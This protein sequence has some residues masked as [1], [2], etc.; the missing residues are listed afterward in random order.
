MTLTRSAVASGRFAKLSSKLNMIADSAISESPLP[1]L[2]CKPGCAFCCHRLVEGVLPEAIAIAQHV[3]ET[4]NEEQIEALK[5]RI[6]QYEVGVL[7]YVK[8]DAPIFRERCPFLVDDLCSIY[9]HRPLD[10]RGYTSTD[11]SQCEDWMKG[12]REPPFQEAPLSIAASLKRGAI[13]ES[14]GAGLPS[15]TY[16]LMGAIGQILDLGEAAYRT[17][18]ATAPVDA[19]VTQSA[20]NTG[21]I[22]PTKTFSDLLQLPGFVELMDATLYGDMDTVSTLLA[23][24]DDPHFPALTDLVLPNVYESQDELEERWSK[25]GDAIGRF[26]NATLH[27]SA[28]FELLP[29]LN[30]FFWP[31]AGKDVR[32]YLER[33]KAKIFRDVIQPG[34]ASLAQPLPSR[35]RPG[36]FRLGFTSPR[37]TYFNG[38]RWATGWLA[39]LSPEIETF[40][41]NLYDQEDTFTGLW[42]RLSDHYF[43]LPVPSAKAAEL[44]RSFDLDALIFTDIGMG[45]RDLQMSNLR[46]ARRQFTAWGHPVTSGSPT[47]DGYLSSELMEPI[48]AQRHYSE[49]LY[50]LPG[51]GLTYPRV[52]VAP[53]DIDPTRFGLPA[54]GFYF[55]AQTAMKALPEHD[56]IYRQICEASG[57]PIAFVA[58]PGHLNEQKLVR[59]FKDAKVNAV[60]VPFLLGPEYHGLMAKADAILDTPAW[61]GANS[62][63]DAFEVGKPVI[64]VAGEFMRAR[65][66]L[67]FHAIAGVSELIASSLDD[68]V[69]LALDSNRQEEAMANLNIEAVYDDPAPTRALEQILLEGFSG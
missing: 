37:L 65:H 67:A 34:F 59:R 11:A 42:R 2:D 12:R 20:I 17:N 44:I 64:T 5:A 32:P 24:F 15:G 41:F 49:K 61:N 56:W 50:L 19:F 53:E 28:T 14:Y 51:S 55:Q 10:C 36:K 52:R 33:T 6:G 23:S 58:P 48:D 7:A 35:S 66:C 62:S 3:K 31:Y 47:I 13:A 40:A 8:R 16:D 4:W 63:V 38:S 18:Q 54:K 27:P 60:I 43:H 21:R 57:K 1:P 69:A 22:V 29:L 9:E 30:T 46:L 26:E 68:Y 39:N 25:L 45:L